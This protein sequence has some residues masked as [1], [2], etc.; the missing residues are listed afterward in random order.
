MA[1]D[2]AD[3]DQRPRR[4]ERGRAFADRSIVGSSRIAQEE[5]EATGGAWCHEATP[6]RKRLCHR[7]ARGVL[8]AQ[9]ASVSRSARAGSCPGKS[10]REGRQQ[11]TLARSQP[12]AARA[13]SARTAQGEVAR[14]EHAAD[15]TAALAG[16]AHELLGTRCRGSAAPSKLLQPTPSPR[17]DDLPERLRPGA[18]A[19]S[20]LDALARC[21]PKAERGLHGIDQA[22]SVR[23]SQ[24]ETQDVLRQRCKLPCST[25][26]SAKRQIGRFL[27]NVA[28]Q[29]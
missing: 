1:A 18:R 3:C 27:A 10:S 2:H 16:A 13:S 21:R 25:R 22:S 23:G 17:R 7:A 24:P 28:G 14:Q 12:A 19:P 29:G 8:R 4:L 9:P 26:P 15:A 20:S 5:A 6:G 11:R